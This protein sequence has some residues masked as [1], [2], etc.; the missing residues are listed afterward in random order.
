[1]RILVIGGTYFLGRAFVSLAC[2]DNEITMINRGSRRVLF[3]H[4]EHV[5]EILCDR[6]ALFA[7]SLLAELK[8]IV[9]ETD[10]Y[11]AV[12]DFC[13]YEKGDISALCEAISGST[14]QYIFVSTTDVYKRG[15]GQ[16]IDEDGEFEERDFGGPA[17][18]YIL[19][20]TAL[21]KELKECSL[22]YG[23]GFTSVRP[24]FIYGPGNYANRESIFFKWIDEAGQVIYPESSDGSFQMVYVEDLAR[25]LL[26]LC[27]NETS[28]GKPF[29]ICGFGE[30]TY[31][32]FCEAL[33]FATGKDFERVLVPVDVINARQIPLPFPLTSAE[34]EHYVSKNFSLIDEGFCYTELGEGLRETYLR[35]KI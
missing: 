34:S 20:K 19:G 2:A 11:D 3:P 31:D 5:K 15:T 16:F 21:E 8:K 17:G 22:Q 26:L 6:H 33:R 30:V 13:A 27:G 23:F 29:N 9:A 35:N 32:S 1:M 12:V 10:I 14:K 7:E 25:I 4:P 24:A 18:A 28:Y